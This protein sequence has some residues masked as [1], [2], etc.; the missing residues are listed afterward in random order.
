MSEI[1][2]Y[3]PSTLGQVDAVDVVALDSTIRVRS[4]SEFIRLGVL[5]EVRLNDLD[6]ERIALLWRGLPSSESARCHMPPYGLRFWLLGE[7]RLEASICWECNNVYGYAGD[8]RLHF[9]FDSKAPT[10]SSLLT[11]CQRAFSQRGGRSRP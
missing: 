2:D 4:V 3:E 1:L 11:Q 8:E 6:A 9:A 5:E 10:S 7:K